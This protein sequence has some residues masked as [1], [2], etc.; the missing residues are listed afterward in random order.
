MP[1]GLFAK[2]R[3][4]FVRQRGFNTA[5]VFCFEPIFE[6]LCLRRFLVVGLCLPLGSGHAAELK[7]AGDLSRLPALVSRTSLS[8]SWMRLLV[9]LQHLDELLNSVRAS[10]GFLG[11]LNCQ[12]CTKLE[13]WRSLASEG[14]SSFSAFSRCTKIGEFCTLIGYYVYPLVVSHLNAK[15]DPIGNGRDLLLRRETSQCKHDSES[16]I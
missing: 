5:S 13:D 6:E 8:R 14:V 1:W 11:G 9:F 10:I 7:L 16:P 2:Q 3:G 12:R 15:S 4:A